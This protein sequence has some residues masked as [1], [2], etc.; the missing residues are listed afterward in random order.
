M[1]YLNHDR[2][3]ASTLVEAYIKKYLEEIIKSC[4]HYIEVL[5]GLLDVGI[6]NTLI[7]HQIS[8]YMNYAQQLL[9]TS[10]RIKN[11][12]H[13]IISNCL[14]NNTYQRSLLL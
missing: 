4:L 10:I 13:R 14:L 7:I 9:V 1:Y 8:F 11:K 5:N 6:D 12:T 3:I 2:H